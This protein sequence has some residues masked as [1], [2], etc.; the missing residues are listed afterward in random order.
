TV[1]ISSQ[2]SRA[3]SRRLPEPYKAHPWIA[4]RRL[5]HSLFKHRND[6]GVIKLSYRS[7]RAVSKGMNTSIFAR[8]F[9]VLLDERYSLRWSGVF[10]EHSFT[11]RLHSSA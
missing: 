8:I 5:F 11:S 7:F 2:C 6:Y 1:P 4:W 9:L 10:P 3:S